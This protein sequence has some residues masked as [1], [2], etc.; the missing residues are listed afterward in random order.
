MEKSNL[1]SS[2][3][4][5][6]KLC[7]YPWV[8]MSA[9]QHGKMIICCNTYESSFMK[10][11]DG[12]VWN[13]KDITNPLE[14]FNSEHYKEIR[15]EMLQG[16]EP[17]YCKKCYDIERNGGKSM[18]QVSLGRYKIDTL[19]EKT[20]LVTGELKE[21]LLSYVHFMWGN[22]C[23]L[24]CKMCDPNSS[25]QLLEEFNEMKIWN[26]NLDSTA[27]QVNWSYE[28][29]KIILEKITPYVRELNVTGGEPLINNDFLEYCHYLND[30]GYS[31]NIDLGFH[32]N[33]SVLPSKF[34]NT[35]KN[36]SKI[37]VKVSIDAIEKDYE[38]IR[39]PG[40]WNTI[41][42][43]IN[44]LIDITDTIPNVVVEFHTVFSSFN[45]HAIPNLI[46]YLLQIQSHKFLNFPNTLLVTSP[47][48]AD[49][50]C[51]P[52][53][54]KQQIEKECLEIVHN[55]PEIKNLRIQD[56]IK[57]LKSNIQYMLSENLN[58]KRFNEFNYNQD[59]L[60][61]VKTEEVIHWY[62]N[63]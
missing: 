51:I 22:K 17:K 4:V 26:G 16:K 39:Y 32:T 10:K 15:K 8:H 46:K 37:N 14:Y 34:V 5:S 36:F 13:L 61:D 35:W 27:I 57:N 12:T 49:S 33:L 56:C 2:P 31:K 52:V 40:K 9:E 38:Y 7:A 60:R 55:M 41:E 19:L 58:Q 47:I 28:K 20:D 45:A 48:Y 6:N 62:K 30:N 3:Q 11:N 25:D 1:P 21:L 24:K 53:T 43:N 50:R 29:N 54:V 59:K 18:R 63:D 42:K 44:K 23:N